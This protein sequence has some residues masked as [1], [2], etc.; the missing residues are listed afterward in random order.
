MN[1]R[2][3]KDKLKEI[4]AGRYHLLG[5]QL[6]EYQ[7]GELKPECTVYIDGLTHFRGKTWEEAFKALDEGIHGVIFDPSEAP[8]GDVDPLK[9]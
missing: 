8:D 1:F 9:P 3:A 4:A 7:S 5:Y 2:E 6:T